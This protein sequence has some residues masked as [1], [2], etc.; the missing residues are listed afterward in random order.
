MR[1]EVFRVA[2]F[3]SGEVVNVELAIVRDEEL[4]TRVWTQFQRIGTIIVVVVRS[5]QATREL[6]PPIGSVRQTRPSYSKGLLAQIRI[7][8]VVEMDES[9]QVGYD[10][11]MRR[12]VEAKLV[13]KIIVLRAQTHW[14]G[15]AQQEQ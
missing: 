9:G 5:D 14:D 13:G 6:D 7:V 3:I 11:V 15:E 4:H 12:N 10:L 8:E 2:E 1:V